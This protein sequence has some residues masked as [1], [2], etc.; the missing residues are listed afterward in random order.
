MVRI[1]T[2]IAFILPLLF[3][4]GCSREGACEATLRIDRSFHRPIEFRLEENE[5][6][7]ILRT[8]IFDGLGGYQKGKVI[9]DKS[10]TLTQEEATL[11]RTA[12]ATV[13]AVAPNE[14]FS[15]YI[16]DGS[17]WTFSG[18]G[19]WPSK[20]KVSTPQS[21]A[22][23][24]GTQPLYDFGRLLWRLGEIDEPEKDFY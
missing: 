12:L 4:I 3:A 7:V 22:S 1:R 18:S 2:Y 11:V 5:S 20:L 14:P 15:P 9:S 10:R 13:V 19:L 17:L 8:K 23:R 6:N 16:R 24:R 21:E